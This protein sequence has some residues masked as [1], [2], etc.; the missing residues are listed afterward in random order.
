LFCLKNK[1][2]SAKVGKYSQNG[3]IGEGRILKSGVKQA[4]A[5]E[6]V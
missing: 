2:W 4:W 5:F 6:K 3:P 1:I